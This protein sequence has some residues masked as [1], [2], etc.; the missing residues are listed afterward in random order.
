MDKEMSW[1]KDQTISI[2]VERFICMITEMA[3][4]E[5]RN[6]ELCRDKYALKDELE[7]AH[8]SVADYKKQ[9]MD[10]LGVNKE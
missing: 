9:L 5:K 3:D 4:L 7:Q 2:P 1:L 6:S 10:L 8:N